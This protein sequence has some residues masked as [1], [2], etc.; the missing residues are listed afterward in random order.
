MARATKA[1]L[2]TAAAV[3]RKVNPLSGSAAEAEPGPTEPTGSATTK[4]SATRT[5]AATK[6]PAK[7]APAKKAPAKKAPAAKKTPTKKAPAA[8]RAPTRKTPAKKAATPTVAAS[9]LPVRDGEAPWTEAEATEVRQ[10]LEDRAAQLRSELAG[11]DLELEGL[12]R[13][14]GEGSGQDQADVGA[15]SFERDQELSLGRNARDMLEQTERALRRLTEGGYG[16]CE[17]CGEAIGKMRVMAFPRATLCLT[18]KQRE[19][20]R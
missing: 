13:E 19:E 5:P 12:M 11:L 9:T 20:R 6:A 16:E 18:C 10:D 14:S 7:K 3:A 2:G 4:A 17:S 1:L 8:T 15:A